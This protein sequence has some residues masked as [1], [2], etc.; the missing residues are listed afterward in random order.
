MDGLIN[1]GGEI[2]KL[3][4]ENSLLKANSYISKYNLSITQAQAVSISEARSRALKDAG[5]I[6]LSPDIPA[7]ILHAIC[8]SPYLTNDNIE[9]VLSSLT[10]AFYYY[11]NETLD[12]ISDDEMIEFIGKNF[13]G[14]CQGSVEMLCSDCLEELRRRVTRKEFK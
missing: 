13:S 8:D 1:F 2:Q 7:K 9:D 10:E 4:C 14:K 11:K 5:R 6:E 3:N 12:I